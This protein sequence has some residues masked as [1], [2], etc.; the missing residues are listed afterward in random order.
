[1]SKKLLFPDDV[2]DFL[3]RR[4]NNQHQTWLTGTGVWPLYVALG[5]P[6]EKDVT[7][8]PGAVRGWVDAWTTWKGDGELV[9]EERQWG[10][11][12]KQRLPA[13][14]VL[15]TP[16]Q[17]AVA[18]LQGGRWKVATQRYERFVQKWPMLVTTTALPRNFDVLADYAGDDFERLIALLS[19][20][21]ANPNA[22]KYLRQL[23]VEGLDTKWIE[24][25]RGLVMDLLQ[26]IRGVQG[27]RE[28][29]SLCGLIRREHRIRV[30]LL[31][32]ELRRAA[33]G[34]SDI[35]APIEE[36]AT[37]ALAPRAAV[38]VENLETGV[39]LA[40]RPG[41]IAFMKLGNAVSVLNALLW[42]RD[43]PVLYWGDIDTHGFAI[44]DRARAVIPGLRSILMDEVTL[45]SH[46]SLWGQEPAQHPDVALPHLT[47]GE[48]IVYS[49]L[50]SNTWGQKVRMEQE[51]I[52]WL[53][54]MET[55]D[56]ALQAT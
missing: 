55:L 16:V 34:L 51:R 36:L 53:Q 52:A 46:R 29:Y 22:G 7:Q 35:E 13:W 40:D 15:T 20:F 6:T 24:K 8:D 44:L 30:R 12:G 17:V 49:G 3:V 19:W 42:L 21:D 14:M 33:G 2:R 41:C 11:L 26:A 4:F 56:V 43:V 47:D 50:R 1:M 54:A 28:F 10:R 25:R 39:A 23:P 27:Y 18:V 31:C 48:R 37:L 32:P 45:L 5:V 38:I 9:W